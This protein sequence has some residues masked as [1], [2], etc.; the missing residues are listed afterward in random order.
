MKKILFLILAL[1]VIVRA[2]EV[3]KSPYIGIVYPYAD[4]MIKADRKEHPLGQNDLRVFYTLSEL[5]GQ[6]IYK[7]AADAQLKLLMQSKRID[8]N[9]TWMLWDRCFEVAPAEARAV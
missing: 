7:N 2:V 6:P 8:A 3:P 9:R 5:S 1:P 4:A